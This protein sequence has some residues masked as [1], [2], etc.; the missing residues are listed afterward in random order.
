MPPAAR[1]AAAI[2]IRAPPGTRVS[3][4]AGVGEGTGAGVGEGV[5]EGVG[6]A[7][8]VTVGAVAVGAGV[9]ATPYDVAPAAVN[10]NS[11]S[12]GCPSADVTL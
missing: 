2:A 6:A 5:D 9:V 7:D 12:I 10:R 4:G 8:A 3:D 11:S 1:N